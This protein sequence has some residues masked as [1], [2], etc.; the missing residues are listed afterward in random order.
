[1]LYDV[2]LL[3]CVNKTGITA[4]LWI[5]WYSSILCLFSLYDMPWCLLW[6]LLLW[7]KWHNFHAAAAADSISFVCNSWKQNVYVNFTYCNQ[8]ATGS[9]TFDQSITYHFV[10]FLCTWCMKSLKVSTRCFRQY[11]VELLILCYWSPV[12]H[13]S[14]LVAVVCHV[15]IVHQHLFLRTYIIISFFGLFLTPGG[16]W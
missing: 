10:V 13:V 9:V 15:K 3:V 6:L 7:L 14:P 12:D 2:W 1:M 8:L 4:S 16:S 11:V 5:L